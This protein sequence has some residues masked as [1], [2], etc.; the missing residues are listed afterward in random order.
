MSMPDTKFDANAYWKDRLGDRFDLTGV[1]FKR[2]SVAYNRWVYRVRTE[3]LDD[4]FGRHGWPIEGKAVLDV[5]CGTGYF[6][7]HWSRR[8]ASSIVGVDVAEVSIERLAQ[9]FSQAEFHC[10]DIAAPDLSIDRTFDYISVFDVLYH[11][12]DDRRFEQAVTNLSRLC[13]PGSKLILTDM[14]GERTVEVVKHVRNRSL[15]CYTEVFAKRGFR[16]LDITPLFFTLM[17]PTRLTN[18]LAYWVGALG[19]E[20][21]TFP[22]RWE[23]LGALTGRVLYRVD[24]GLRGRFNRGPSHHLAVFEFMGT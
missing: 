5:G 10:A 1:G 20:T 18:R 11:I 21:L 19:W 3:L 16:L 24:S 22:A 6:V 15:N 9:R 17:P 4:L 8:Q 12:V 23:K 2:R 13:Q 7:D 14:F